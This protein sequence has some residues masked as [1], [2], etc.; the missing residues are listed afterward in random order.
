M[1][2]SPESMNGRFRVDGA[3]RV[4]QRQLRERQQT[5]RGFGHAYSRAFEL[6][7]TPPLFGAAGYGLDRWLGIVPVCT[8]LFVLVAAVGLFARLYYGY[9]VEMEAHERSAPWAAHSGGNGLR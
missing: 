8:I 3:G 6:A 5:Y 7:L 4:E 2:G 9:A 1:T